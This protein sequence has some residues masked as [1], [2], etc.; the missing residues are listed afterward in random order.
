MTCFVWFF[1]F[2][3]WNF[4]TLNHFHLLKLSPP[5]RQPPDKLSIWLNKNYSNIDISFKDFLL[6]I[7]C[8]FYIDTLL[9]IIWSFLYLIFVYDC[10]CFLLT[11]TVSSNSGPQAA[12]YIEGSMA[13]FRWSS[14]IQCE[15]QKIMSIIKMRKR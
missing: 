11:R 7:K 2:N 5:F 9:A 13:N 15:F 12:E 3:N 4:L 10:L 1:F 8:S 14:L 6:M